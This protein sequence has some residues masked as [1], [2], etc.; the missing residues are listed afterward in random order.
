MNMYD[1]LKYKKIKSSQIIADFCRYLR[2]VKYIVVL[3]RSFIEQTGTIDNA[4][5]FYLKHRLS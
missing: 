4:R 2:E 5:G 1:I 3:G